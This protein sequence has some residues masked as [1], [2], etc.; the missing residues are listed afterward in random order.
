M[1]ENDRF[2][3]AVVPSS[4]DSGYKIGEL[5]CFCRKKKAILVGGAEGDTMHDDRLAGFT[6]AFEA[7]G[8]EALGVTRCFE[9]SE[10]V[11]KASDLITAN[12]YEAGGDYVLAIANT[13]ENFP[14]H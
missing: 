13:L 12:M 14:R 7:G 3:G 2:I 5:A 9:S 10:G 1:L 11:T 6:D 4:Y 8:G